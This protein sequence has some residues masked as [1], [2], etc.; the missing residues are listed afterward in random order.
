MGLKTVVPWSAAL[1]ADEAGVRRYLPNSHVGL[2]ERG[3]DGRE[4]SLSRRRCWRS[5]RVLGHSFDEKPVSQLMYQDLKLCHLH[6]SKAQ[7]RLELEYIGP[8]LVSLISAVM[9]TTYLV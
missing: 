5:E 8:V 2:D 6:I 3:R 4:A 9:K 7:L 1:Q